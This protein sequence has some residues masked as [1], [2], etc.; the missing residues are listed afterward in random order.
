MLK[1]WGPLLVSH[2]KRVS[3]GPIPCCPFYLQMSFPL[4]QFSGHLWIPQRYL[5]G[6]PWSRV[7][8]GVLLSPAFSVLSLF[9]EVA[10]CWG[11]GRP[12][13]PCLP[14]WETVRMKDNAQWPGPPRSCPND[15]VVPKWPECTC[16]L[17]SHLHG[18][19]HSR[20]V[21]CKN[22]RLMTWFYTFARASHLEPR[23]RLHSGYA[24][25]KKKPAKTL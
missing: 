11:N 7:D 4:T 6:L 15:R 12:T 10:P 20:Q 16:D 23:S 19:S 18:R 8:P 22:T 13:P 17:V 5:W 14:L 21:L 2:K 9:R 25:K 1:P 3:S 24:R